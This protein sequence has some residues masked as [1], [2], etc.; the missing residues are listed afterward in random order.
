[1]ATTKGE[2][3]DLVDSQLTIDGTYNWIN[4][5][6]GWAQW[7]IG[8]IGRTRFQFTWRGVSTAVDVPVY[9]SLVN[10]SL[11]VTPRSDIITAN[12]QQAVLMDGDD[13]VYKRPQG[14]DDFLRKL[15]ITVVYSQSGYA[16]NS[17]AQNIRARINEGSLWDA[18]YFVTYEDDPDDQDF[19][20]RKLPVLYSTNIFNFQDTKGDLATQKARVYFELGDEETGFSTDLST[21]DEYKPDD[22][23][24]DSGLDKALTPIAR[25]SLLT[26]EASDAYKNRTKTVKGNVTFRTYAGDPYDTKS[27]TASINVAPR[28]YPANVREL[29][30]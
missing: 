16:T 14:M 25:D 11:T 6:G 3:N 18:I 26:L 9:N 23:D 29:E 28:N 21:S 15:D 24:D 2:V 7:A 8:N 4:G 13:V 22:Q 10:G 1:V 12:S 30:S 19:E 20:Y 27:L 17:S 5:D